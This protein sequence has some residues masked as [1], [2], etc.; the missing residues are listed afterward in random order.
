MLRTK[1]RLFAEKINKTER[2]GNA[3]I[4]MVHQ[5]QETPEF[6]KVLLGEEGAVPDEPIVEHVPADFAPAKCQLY[7]VCLGMGYLELPQVEVKHGQLKPDLLNSKCVYILD[8]FSDLFIWIGKK[9]TRLVSFSHIL[10]FKR[11]E[12]KCC[13][14]FRRFEPLG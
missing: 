11:G 6:W 12:S 10:G 1:T 7:H 8:C 3:E 14:R 2:K 5:E 13:V 4:E 9:S